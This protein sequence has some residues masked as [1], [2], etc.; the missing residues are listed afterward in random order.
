MINEQPLVV[1]GRFEAGRPAGLQ[2]G[3][4]LSVPLAITF[5]SLPVTPGCSYAWQ[6]SI[7]D[8]THLDWRQRFHVRETPQ[9]PM[10]PPPSPS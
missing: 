7:D 4:P 9:R 1:H 10:G 2:A 8:S 3:T 6:L 5:P